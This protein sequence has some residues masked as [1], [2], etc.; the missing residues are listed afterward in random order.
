MPPV[1]SNSRSSTINCIHTCRSSCYNARSCTIPVATVAL[2][3]LFSLI[4]NHRSYEVSCLLRS[5]ACWVLG[6]LLN[7]YDASRLTASDHSKVL[8][9]MFSILLNLPNGNSSL[10]E[11]LTSHIVNTAHRRHSRSLSLSSRTWTRSP[12]DSDLECIG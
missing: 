4:W 3:L 5:D 8:P 6:L 7:A 12:L 1:R 11:R 9:L 10:G 2:L